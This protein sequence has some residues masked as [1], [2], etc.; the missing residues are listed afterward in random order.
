MTKIL[1]ILA[2]VIV[3][4][5]LFSCTA[6]DNGGVGRTTEPAT[7]PATGTAEQSESESSGVEGAEMVRGF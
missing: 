5:F 1:K 7:A 3:L 2:G 6:P 4:T